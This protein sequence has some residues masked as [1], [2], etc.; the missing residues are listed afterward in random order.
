[1]DNIGVNT[2]HERRDGKA[3]QSGPETRSREALPPRAYSYIR[4]ST[5]EQAKGASL[6][7]QTAAAKAWADRHGIE[8]DHWE[9][10]S[11]GVVGF[12]P[13]PITECR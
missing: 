10:C 4:F 3:R 13:G 6:E 11:V 9:G 7:R 12:E 1:V 2:A 5:P 8:L